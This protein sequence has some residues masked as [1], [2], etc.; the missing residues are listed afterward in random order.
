VLHPLGDS[1]L[2]IIRQSGT[3]S[4]GVLDSI[5]RSAGTHSK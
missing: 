1:R 4:Q 2:E 3:R 5:R